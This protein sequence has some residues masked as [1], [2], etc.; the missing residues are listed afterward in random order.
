[1][2]WKGWIFSLQL[3]VL[4][5]I[6]WLVKEN[7]QL[8]DIV[9]KAGNRSSKTVAKY[10]VVIGNVIPFFI[11]S[12]E[13]CPVGRINLLFLLYFQHYS[14]FQKPIMYESRGLRKHCHR[15]AK[16]HLAPILL[17]FFLNA[18]SPGKCLLWNNSAD[19]RILHIIIWV[20]GKC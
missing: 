18:R 13:M 15:K 9:G 17:L 4:M 5:P 12:E 7:N 3:H 19:S 11:P 6:F 8:E 20:M 1:M 10:A 14:R 16:D 2:C